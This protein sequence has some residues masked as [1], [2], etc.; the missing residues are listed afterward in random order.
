MPDWMIKL[1]ALFDPAVAQVV[2]DLGKYKNASNEKA[3]R[4]LGWS[5]RSNEEA[6]IATAESMLKLGLLKVSKKS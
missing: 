6:I 2:T 4:M 1:V 3:R 5:P